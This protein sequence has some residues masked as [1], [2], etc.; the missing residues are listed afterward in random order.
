MLERTSIMP[1]M[2]HLLAWVCPC[3]AAHYTP[4]LP[5]RASRIAEKNPPDPSL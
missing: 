3:I 5:A 4:R 1:A 2:V